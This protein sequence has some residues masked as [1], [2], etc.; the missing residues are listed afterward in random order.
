MKNFTFILFILAFVSYSF[1]TTDPSF[2]H[3]TTTYT[4]NH[5]PYKQSSVSASI[6]PF[7]SPVYSISL[8]TKMIE[9]AKTSIDV[10]KFRFFL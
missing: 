9:A 3:Q 2:D 6:T 8:L 1:A 5:A 4:A 10:G 7:F